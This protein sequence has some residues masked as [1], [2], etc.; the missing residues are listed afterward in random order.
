MPPPRIATLGVAVAGRAVHVCLRR[1]D[2]YAYTAE[3][4][5]GPGAQARGEALRAACRRLGAARRLPAA[6]AVP[7]AGVHRCRLHLPDG[8]R[9]AEHRAVVR[10]HIRRALPAPASAWRYRLTGEHRRPRLLAARQADLLVAR[11]LLRNAGLRPVAVLASRDALRHGGG[12]PPG[13]LPDT[14]ATRL[15]RALAEAA[16][17]PGADNLLRARDPSAYGTEQP[18]RVAAGAAL[19]T[20]LA[21]VAA[22]A[23]W[24]QSLGPAPA[25]T[26]DDPVEAPA[27]PSPEPATTDPEETE[28][29][30]PT[31]EEPDPPDPDPAD[32]RR[33]AAPEYLDALAEA[34]PE[35]TRLENVELDEALRIEALATQPD[36][37]DA[38]LAS[39]QEAGF[40]S[41]ELEQMRRTG[42]GLRSLAVHAEPRAPEPPPP[43]E[44]PETSLRAQLSHL[45]QRLEHHG[46]GVEDLQRDPAG[47]DDPVVV[48]LRLLGTYGALHAWLTEEADAAPARGLERLQLRTAEPPQV[49]G[50]LTLT[51]HPPETE[52]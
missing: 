17:R 30:S 13:P 42:P 47:E 36:D 26:P 20:G 52:P 12:P 51:L 44:T 6:M 8:L 27:D 5:R 15:A 28:E 22:H 40:D 24:G 35:G 14:P 50:D 2:R 45:T 39:L 25:S 19:A 34:L 1:R 10:M 37:A 11:S 43:A 23:H 38:F 46:V 29:P 4:L 32:A 31:A 41:V 7:E 18:L 21:G 49:E 3:P 9:R 16:R 48:R 33:Q